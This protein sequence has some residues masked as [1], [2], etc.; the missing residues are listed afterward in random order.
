MNNVNQKKE[1]IQY[2]RFIK[3]IIA[4]LMKIFPNIPQRIKEDYHYIKD[5]ISLVSVYT[6]GNV[7][8]RR[9]LIP[10]EFLTEEICAT[11]DFKEYETVFMNVAVLMNQPQPVISTQGMHR[12]TPRAYRTPTLTTASPQGKKRKQS[13]R[14][15]KPGSHKDNPEHV[16][17]DDDKEE[18]K[19][20]EKEGDEMGSLETRTKE[21]QTL[22]PTTPRSL[23]KILSSDKNIDPLAPFHY[24]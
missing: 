7:L 1:A 10:D 14:E 13:V 12:S 5:D 23:R 20:D 22:I 6:T 16:N 19:V 21:M 9:M 15:L 3:L 4:N 11:D 2:P 24:I 8:V 18:E 17:D